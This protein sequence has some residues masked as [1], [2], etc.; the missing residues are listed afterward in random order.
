[1]D[2]TD[3]FVT[4]EYRVVT[5]RV[6]YKTTHPI[7]RVFN[8]V[9]SVDR[10]Y[11]T[12]C[13]EFSG[14]KQRGYGIIGLSPGDRRSRLVHRLVYEFAVGP[15]ADGFE[16]D[17]LCRN[18]ACCNTTHLEPVTSRTNTMRGDTLPA[19]EAARMH[20]INGHELSGDNLLKRARGHR[21]CKTCHRERQRARVTQLHA[22][23]LS[24]RG[25]ALR[26]RPTHCPHGHAYTQDNLLKRSGGRLGCK[27]CQRARNARR[28]DT[29]T[30]TD[31]R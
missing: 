16:L 29:T 8:K 4:V 28:R 14:T 3:E 26:P 22:A 6:P 7:V 5:H 30:T 15:I 10:G 11:A 31:P 23:G 12:E 13:I 25:N 9:R 18:R 17:H 27:A 20:C 21:D 1:M 19:R 2:T 24:S